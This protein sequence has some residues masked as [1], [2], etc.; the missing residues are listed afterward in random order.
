MDINN[1]NIDRKDLDAD[2]KSVENSDLQSGNNIENSFSSPENVEELKTDNQIS[3]DNKSVNPDFNN[4]SSENSQNTEENNT[5]KDSVDET[6]VSAQPPVKQEKNPPQKSKE[7]NYQISLV[8]E[9]ILRVRISTNKSVSI[10]C[11]VKD[12]SGDNQNE[13][14]SNRIFIH[15]KS[16]NQEIEI[17]VNIGGDSDSKIP[18]TEIPVE[19]K[20]VKQEKTE[21][22]LTPN[23]LVKDLI[24]RIEN[25]GFLKNVP[26][27]PEEILDEKLGRKN[28]WHINRALLLDNLKKG[29]ISGLIVY[30]IS[31]IAFYNYAAKKNENQE[32]VEQRRLIVM[33]DLPEN[34]N[35]GQNIDDPY[36]PPEETPKNSETGDEKNFVPPVKPKKIPRPPRVTIPKRT[37]TENTDTNVASLNRELDSLR[38]ANITGKDTGVV[39]DTMIAKGNLVPDSLLR[40]LNENEVGLVGKFPSNWKQMDSR[41]INISQKEFTGVIL[42]DTTAKRKEEALT[43]NVQ[44]DTKG[45]YWEMYSFKDVMSEDSLLTIYSIPPKTE[46][47]QTYYRFYI[48]GKTDNVFVSAFVETPFF[49]K[50]KPEIERVVRSIKIQKPQKKSGLN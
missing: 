10:D 14:Q 16:F 28:P 8:D 1:E 47:N 26:K 9:N 4:Q 49:E 17:F 38:K 11:S 6:T 34:L 3:S 12:R 2:K 25:T 29:F 36:K 42:V 35:S 5:L 41:Q 24:Q 18:V 50:Y 40:A 21:K 7:S 45:E 22:K 44:L 15:P 32:V 30:F 31:I 39:K 43:M 37:V 33:Q 27:T 46:A 19:N 48:A 23:P 13:T 20:V